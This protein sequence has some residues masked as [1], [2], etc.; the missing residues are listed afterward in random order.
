MHGLCTYGYALRHV[1][2]QYAN[3]DP[4]NFKAIK[5]RFAGPTLPGQTIQTDMWKE[6]NRIY[7]NCSVKETGKEIITGAYVDLIKSYDGRVF[8]ANQSNGNFGI[9]NV[10]IF[11]F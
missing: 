5:A 9:N 1:L 2:A 10:R 7:F 3:N 4:S 11:T 8:K 6:G